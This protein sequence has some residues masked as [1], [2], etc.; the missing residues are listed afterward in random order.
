MEDLERGRGRRRRSF[1][2]VTLA[3]N[4]SPPPC[5]M[6]TR[7]SLVCLRLRCLVLSSS[8]CLPF[9]CSPGSLLLAPPACNRPPPTVVIVVVAFAGQCQETF[10]AIK[11]RPPPPAAERIFCPCG[12]G[13]DDRP[14]T[15]TVNY[16]SELPTAEELLCTKAVR[17]VSLRAHP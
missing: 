13:E 9:T 12:G 14:D 3:N 11:P 5:S 2:K 8:T 1:G 4:E 10:C 7:A 6:H 16:L 17:P 15:A